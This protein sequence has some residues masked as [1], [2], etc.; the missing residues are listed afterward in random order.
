MRRR[1]DPVS[2][3]ATYSAGR[4]DFRPPHETFFPDYNPF[5]SSPDLEKLPLSRG[6]DSSVR[7]CRELRFVPRTT[8]RVLSLP[9][10]HSSFP[11]YRHH[12]MHGSELDARVGRSDRR[13]PTQALVRQDECFSILFSITHCFSKGGRRG[14]KAIPPLIRLMRWDRPCSAAGEMIWRESP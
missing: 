12:N 7:T 13:R 11:P 2:H 6:C 5:F 14:I 4:E 3:R 8:D 9:F 1:I 10:F